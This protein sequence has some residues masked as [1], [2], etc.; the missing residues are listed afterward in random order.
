[1]SDGWTPTRCQL[2][3]SFPIHLQVSSGC[4]NSPCAYGCS[5]IGNTGFSC[6]CPNGYQRIAQVTRH[7]AHTPRFTD[8]FHLHEKGHCISTITPVSSGGESYEYGPNGLDPYNQSKDKIISTEGCFSCKVNGG[9]R[10]RR[11]LN[12]SNGTVP[13]S[14]LAALNTSTPLI[15]TV[16][17]EQTK[18]RMR[19]IQLQPALRSLKVCNLLTR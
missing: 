6:G 15:M 13:D 9:A 8:C 3:R 1:V 4:S 5:P 19:I 11:S 12:K 7:V 14:S 16:P 2:A 17:L 10:G 18:H